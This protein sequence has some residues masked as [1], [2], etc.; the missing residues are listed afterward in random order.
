MV[1]DGLKVLNYPIEKFI[2]LGIARDYELYKF[3]SEFFMKYSQKS[4]TFDNVNTN[5]TNIFPLAGGERDFRELGFED[6]NF[7]I[8]IMNKPIINY[9]IKSNPRGVKNIFIGLKEYESLF[10][11]MHLFNGL[12]S[13]VVLLEKKGES[14]IKT[15]YGIKDKVD[16]E[17]PICISGA[18]SISDYDEKRMINL[19]EKE[20][21]DIILFSF[22]HNEAILRSPKGFAYA[23]LK[24]NIEVE[25]IKEKETISDN[26]YYDNALTGTAIF[27]KAKYLF[28]AIEAELAKPNP[29]HFYLNSLNN[30]LSKKKVVIFNVDKFVPLRTITN[31]KEFNYWEDYFHK[32]KYHP[33]TRKFND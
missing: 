33:Y 28:E 1:R 8:P 23:K 11:N 31:Y 9:A 26:P 16:P 29:S 7:M 18:T 32:L 25:E 12:N 27:K 10:K 5:V 20:D 13:E 14:L 2:S 3:W 24:N 17:E 21:V 15:L 30:I 22:S 4:I 19:M 6:L